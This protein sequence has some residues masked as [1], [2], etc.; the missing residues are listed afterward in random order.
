MARCE[1]P[2]YATAGAVFRG[3]PN[4]ICSSGTFLPVA[5]NCTPRQRGSETPNF[6]PA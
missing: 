1:S 3:D 6:S 2:R 5:R 4:Q